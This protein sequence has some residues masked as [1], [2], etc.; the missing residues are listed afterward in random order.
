MFVITGFKKRA[1]DEPSPGYYFHPSF[2]RDHPELLDHV[3]RTYPSGVKPPDGEYS[4]ADEDARRGSPTGS[5]RRKLVRSSSNVRQHKGLGQR[6]VK[7]PYLESC[8]NTA[9]GVERRPLPINKAVYDDLVQN[10]PSRPWFYSG[11]PAITEAAVRKERAAAADARR[12]AEADSKGKAK[13]VEGE[14][15]GGGEA[16]M[17]G[18]RR[19]NGRS[20]NCGR[21]FQNGTGRVNAW[22]YRRREDSPATVQGEGKPEAGLMSYMP[23]EGGHPVWNGSPRSGDFHGNQ[24]AREAYGP[25]GGEFR[26][27]DSFHPQPM[28]SVQEDPGQGDRGPRRL[29][30]S[31]VFPAGILQGSRQHLWDAQ[32]LRDLRTPYLPAQARDEMEA[33]DGAAV[34]RPVWNG[35]DRGWPR[36]GPP[37]LQGSTGA[38][39]WGAAEMAQDTE[40][41]A[42][43]K[44]DAAAP[45]A[46]KWDTD[47][48]GPMPRP[49]PHSKQDVI[50]EAP[51]QPRRGGVPYKP[52]PLEYRK[53][54]EEAVNEERPNGH[55]LAVIAASAGKPEVKEGVSPSHARA[56]EAM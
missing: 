18:G 52:P 29:P 10:K 36:S 41:G 50:M 9:W 16:D 15:R 4:S 26:H 56:M 17:G 30:S 2:R 45:A 23:Y 33:D 11:S 5:P 22:S 7:K 27:R 1:R 3:R 53:E 35:E 25:P 20:G 19:R 51:P 54:R 47:P 49:L 6:A 46:D 55:G 24:A 28:D 39:D 42:A 34:W 38:A 13:A 44:R 40:A 37:Q 48:S 31:S 21:G 12:K 43:A 14:G 32:E 8:R